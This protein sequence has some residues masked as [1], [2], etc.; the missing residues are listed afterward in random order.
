MKFYKKLAAIGLAATMILGLTACGG[1]ASNPD[2]NIPSTSPSASTSAAPSTQPAKE[3]SGELL[4]EGSTSVQKIFQELIDTFMAKNPKVEIEYMGDGSSAGIKAAI[5]ET[6][7]IGTASRAIKDEE[8]SQGLEIFQMADDAIAV[9]VNPA[10]KVKELT[11]DQIAQIYKKEITNW[12][13]VG[14]D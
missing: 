14:G 1:T 5:A 4:I 7:N 9:V 3:L 8:K 6:A 13:E 11:K 10:N 12:K 2:T